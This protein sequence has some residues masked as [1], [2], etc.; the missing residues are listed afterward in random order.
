MYNIAVP[1]NVISNFGETNLAWA[2]LIIL[3]IGII[4]IILAIKKKIG[5][6]IIPEVIAGFIL[7]AM[8]MW[9]GRVFIEYPDFTLDK[10]KEE[11]QVEVYQ[12]E[13]KKT[14]CAT[15]A[16]IIQTIPLVKCIKNKQ[17]TEDTTKTM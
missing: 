2:E 10:T 5:K 3:I 8:V 15:V 11:Q 6:K 13:I 14:S 1:E 4:T 17:T 7:V 9:L 12:T 16:V